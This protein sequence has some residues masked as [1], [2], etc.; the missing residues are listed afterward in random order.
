MQFTFLKAGKSKWFQQAGPVAAYLLGHELAN[1]EHLVAMVGICDE[2]AILS[3]GI[4]YRKTV[5]GK[6]ADTTGGLF[7][8]QGHGA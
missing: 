6:C 3:K 5:R 2:V 7:L 1:A 4:E 8:V